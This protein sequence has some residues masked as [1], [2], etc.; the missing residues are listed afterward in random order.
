MPDANPLV[1]RLLG[2][3]VELDNEVDRLEHVVRL[4][5]QRLEDDEELIRRIAVEVAKLR[6]KV[7]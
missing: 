4:L 5:G 6:A 2:R 3:V 7:N 1:E